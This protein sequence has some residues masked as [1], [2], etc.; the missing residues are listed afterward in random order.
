MSRSC[1]RLLPATP[2]IY[3]LYRVKNPSPIRKARP[4]DLPAVYELIL[5]LARFERAPEEVSLSMEQ[6]H[7]DAFG[8][9]PIVEILVVESGGTVAAA[10]LFYEKYSTWKG[11]CLHLE[12]LIVS[13]RFRAQGLGSL[14]FD[15]VLELCAKRG[16]RRMEW[17]VLNWNAPALAFYQ[18]Y[19]SEVLEE[20]LTC[21]LSEER[22]RSL[23]SATSSEE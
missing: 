16:Y 15:A 14:L 11:R 4:E 10:A 6:L 5:E 17:Q 23:A 12:D 20:W 1:R 13:E 22:I 8:P 2:A 3:F 7:S 19:G 18:K 21:R 9:D